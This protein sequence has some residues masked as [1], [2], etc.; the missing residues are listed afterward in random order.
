MKKSSS[1]SFWLAVTFFLALFLLQA[2]ST[3]ATT[4]PTFDEVAHLPAGIAQLDVG[5]PVFNAEHPPLVKMLAA[6]PLRGMLPPIDSAIPQWRSLNEWEFGRLL[7][8]PTQADGFPKAPTELFFWARLPMIVLGMLLCLTCT[9]WSRALYG[10]AGAMTT[11]LFAVGCPTLLAHSRLVTTDV[12]VATFA[13]M[14]MFMSWRWFLQPTWGRAAGAGIALGCCLASKY[15]GVVMIPALG[16][17]ATVSLWRHPLHRIRLLELAHPLMPRRVLGAQVLTAGALSLGVIALSYGPPFNPL[18]WLEGV[19]TVGFNHLEG[20]PFYLMGAFSTDGFP[21]YFFQAFL[22]KS[23][24]GFLLGLVLWG[25]SRAFAR[26]TPADEAALA[27]PSALPFLLFPVVLYG[28]FIVRMAPN[29]GVRYLIPLLP[30]LF[31]LL[32]ELGPRLARGHFRVLLAIL[33][34]MQGMAAF[35]ARHDPLSYFNGLWGCRGPQAIFCLDDSNLDWGQDLARISDVVAPLRT[36]GDTVRLLYFGTAHP[37]AYLRG[38]E[39]MKEDEILSPEPA[40]YV[41]SLHRLNRLLEQLGRPNGMD[42]F[43]RFA[44]VATV[45]NTYYV[46]DFRRRAADAR[47]SGVLFPLNSSATVSRV[48]VSPGP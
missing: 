27:P 2:V 36:P 32:G 42:W 30:F 10:S 26:R 29:I 31:V 14:T 47:P 17:A 5:H 39:R 45:G 48:S 1:R 15:S 43:V 11:L 18:L 23:P 24:P 41:V 44:P 35:Q 6:L 3:L 20:Y 8:F 4:A 46:Y 38:W 22:L 19:R 13:V 37:G 7:L 28:I 21:S 9:L 12:P 40:L 34:G 25:A 33:L 16:L